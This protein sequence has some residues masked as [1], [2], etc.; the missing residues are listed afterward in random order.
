MSRV[1]IPVGHAADSSGLAVGGMAQRR[2]KL[3]AKAENS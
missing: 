3:T 2:A 1:G